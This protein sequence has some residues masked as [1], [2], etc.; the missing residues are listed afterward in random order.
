VN[1]RAVGTPIVLWMWRRDC[2]LGYIA[3]Q[4]FQKVNLC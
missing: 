3:P 2:P 4:D 1:G